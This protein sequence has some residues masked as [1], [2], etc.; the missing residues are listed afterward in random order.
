MSSF[1]SDSQ[2]SGSGRDLF[3]STSKQV[4]MWDTILDMAINRWEAMH[5]EYFAKYDNSLRNSVIKHQDSGRATEV[6]R[7]G[8]ILKL[9]NIK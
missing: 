4:Q 9:H 8:G 1:R 5:N 7:G 6:R 2:V 3:T